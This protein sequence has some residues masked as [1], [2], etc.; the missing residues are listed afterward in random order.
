MGNGDLS[1]I[2][3]NKLFT[4]FDLLFQRKVVNLPANFLLNEVKQ[5]KYKQ[6]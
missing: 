3:I 6:L 1:F 2:F 5:I 4:R